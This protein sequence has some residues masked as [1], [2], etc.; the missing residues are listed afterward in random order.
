MSIWVQVFW[1]NCLKRISLPRGYVGTLQYVITADTN[2]KNMDETLQTFNSCRHHR[3]VYQ[4]RILL[5]ESDTTYAVCLAAAVLFFSSSSP[6]PDL[7]QSRPRTS[8]VPQ[9]ISAE[10]IDA[11][12]PLSPDDSTFNNVCFSVT[13]CACENLHRFCFLGL[14]WQSLYLLLS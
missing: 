5:P 2:S 11:S 1:T 4:A 9:V 12:F 14:S 10:W 3:F 8:E 6:H 7:K 13:C